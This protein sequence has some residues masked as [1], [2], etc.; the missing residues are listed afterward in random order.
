MKITKTYGEL[1]ALNNVFNTLSQRKAP[2]SIIIAK[3]IQQLKEIMSE[4]DEKRKDIID[5]NALVDDEGNILGIY[6]ENDKGEKERVK[7]P[8]TFNDIEWQDGVT[9]ESVL[10][11][12]DELTK[13][14][15]EVVL[16]PINCDLKYFD[17]DAK[18]RLSIREYIDKEV[19]ADVILFLDDMSLLEKLM[20]DE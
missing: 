9:L 19:E 16:Y 3:N 18:E 14:E 10:G 4:Y 15:K 5:K 11:E 20:V 7:E 8:K 13:E 12:I 2:F 6:V 17:K 1:I